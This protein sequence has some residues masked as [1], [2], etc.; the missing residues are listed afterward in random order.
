M[1]TITVTDS[2]IVVRLRH[3]NEPPKQV[4]KTKTVWNSLNP[5]YHETAIVE[6]E[7]EGTTF[8]DVSA[9]DATV[10]SIP[11][12]PATIVGRGYRSIS[13]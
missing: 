4:L 11:R 6:Y 10:R 7:F 12:F 9:P 2:F 3:Q 5:D 1:D 13:R 8:I